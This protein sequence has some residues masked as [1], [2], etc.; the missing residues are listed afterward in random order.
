MGFGFEELFLGF[1]LLQAAVED[2][3]CVGDGGIVVAY[4]GYSGGEKFFDVV[5][6]PDGECRRE[7]T[8]ELKGYVFVHPSAGVVATARNLH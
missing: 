6:A 5:V 3:H 7:P 2:F 1:G 4:G 8:G